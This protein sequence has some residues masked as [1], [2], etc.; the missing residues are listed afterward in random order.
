M[1]KKETSVHKWRQNPAVGSSGHTLCA[2]PRMPGSSG[3]VQVKCVRACVCVCVC[4]CVWSGEGA[5]LLSRVVTELTLCDPMDC[6]PPGSLSM[7]F[8]KRECW[9]RLSFPTAGDLPDLMIKPA[10]PALAGRCFTT[11]PPGKPQ[12]WHPNHALQIALTSI[13]CSERKN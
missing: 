13:L 5:Q 10:S 6:S 7:G 11:V 3:R 12:P 1:T 4:V 9:S 8:S 2:G